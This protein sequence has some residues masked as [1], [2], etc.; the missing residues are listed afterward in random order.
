MVVAWRHQA[1][2]LSKAEMLLTHW[3]RVT[4]WR[5]CVSKLTI[6]GSDNGLSPGRRLAIIWTRAGILLIGTLG[7]NFREMLS[8]IHTFS[9][10]KMHLKTSSAKRRPFCLGLNVLI[11]HWGINIINMQRFSFDKMS[12]KQWSFCYY[13]NVLKESLWVVQCE[14]VQYRKK[15]ALCCCRTY[16]IWPSHF[17][18]LFQKTPCLRQLW[19]HRDGRRSLRSG[20]GRGHHNRTLS[21]VRP[22]HVQS[23]LRIRK[24]G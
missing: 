20:I 22:G 4:Q 6:I 23:R 21:R 2:F 13:L 11:G 9:F 16:G 1:I 10:K 7:T 15:N 14:F 5:V 3:G 8:G 19:R 24:G 18:S 17:F 12:T